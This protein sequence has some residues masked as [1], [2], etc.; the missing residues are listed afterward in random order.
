MP[1]LELAKKKKLSISRVEEYYNALRTNIQLSGENI[2]VIAVSSTFP[3]E[4]KTTTSTNLAL[5]FANAG[6]KTL[7]IDADIRNSKMLGGV[8]RSS[9]KITGLTEYL[10]GNTDLSQGLCETDEENL[11]VI[12]SGQASPNPTALVQSEKFEVMMDVLRRHYDYIIVDTPP[13]GMVIDAT[14]I[15]KFCD[16]SMLV[17]AS[18]VVKRKMVQKSKTQLEQS[19]TPFLGVILNKYNVEA[20]KYGF[21]GSYGNYGDRL[22]EEKKSEK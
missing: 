14:L 3:G 4:G 18:N 13:I 5:T 22:R 21:Y 17:V 1:I 20:D 12:T 10:S 8:F 11:F 9:E 19:S 7:L 16:A 15:S 2:K 6:Y